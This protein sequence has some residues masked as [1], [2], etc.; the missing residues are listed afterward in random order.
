VQVFVDI[1]D[2]MGGVYYDVPV[3]MKYFDPTQNLT[4]NVS[5]GYQLL[6]GYNAMGVFRFR[7]GYANADLGRIEVQQDFLA[8]VASQM[9]SLG[10]IPNLGKIV[11]IISSRVDTNLSAAN[12]AYFARQFLKCDMG[13][14][15]F[16]P[17]L[18]AKPIPKVG[19]V[20]SGDV[21]PCLIENGNVYNHGSQGFFARA[22]AT[23]GK[24]DRLLDMLKWMMPYDTERHPTEDTYTPPYAIVNCWQ[25]LPSFN[26][27]ALFCFL[28]GSVA[29]AMRGVYEWMFG[30][31][32]TLYGLEI[33]PCL[34][35]GMTTA[36]AEFEYMG[37]KLTLKID[38]AKVFIDGTELTEKTVDLISG[39]EAFI[40]KA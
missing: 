28:T 8:S 1:I 11:D 13:Y 29:M 6:D 2:A 12:I 31:R 26:H 24:G 4:I 23:A 5:K 36:E 15:L 14:K 25:Q 10:N 38:G 16:W 40:Y 32:P 7:S 30:I 3:D 9:I 27:R 34:P 17:Y 20:A 33:A 22:L 39:K 19:R 37:K 21:P 18:G 35:E